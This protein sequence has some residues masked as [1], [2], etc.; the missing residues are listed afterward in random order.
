[1]SLK[2]ISVVTDFSIPP[3]I[4]VSGILFNHFKLA[5]EYMTQATEQLGYIRSIRKEL[6]NLT[7]NPVGLAS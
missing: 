5:S 4:I 3:S 7:E 2:S 1:M 6:I